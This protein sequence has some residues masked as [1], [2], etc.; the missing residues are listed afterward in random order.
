MSWS[1]KWHFCTTVKDY[2]QNVNSMITNIKHKCAEFYL[3]RCLVAIV[4]GLEKNNWNKDNF[5]FFVFSFQCSLYI[6]TTTIFSLCLV[7]FRVLP[8]ILC[9]QLYLV[10][11]IS[12]MNQK[13]KLKPFPFIYL[14][15]TLKHNKTRANGNINA[16]LLS[17]S[18]NGLKIVNAQSRNLIYGAT[19]WNCRP[20]ENLLATSKERER[21]TN[22]PDAIA[23]KYS[24]FQQ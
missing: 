18:L 20:I 19:V 10:T 22:W 2:Q 3:F 21:E 24:N 15:K 9:E 7:S 14:T 23:S 8:A 6:K 1:N 4:Y 11:R 17:L 13:H 5:T 12:E 16:L